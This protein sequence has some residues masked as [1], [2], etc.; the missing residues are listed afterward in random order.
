MVRTASRVAGIEAQ[1]SVYKCF[2]VQ[3]CDRKIDNQ[4]EEDEF[5]REQQSKR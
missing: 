4:C 2:Q 1:S 5:S 3:L